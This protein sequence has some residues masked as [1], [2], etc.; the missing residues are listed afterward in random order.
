MLSYFFLL[1]CEGAKADMICAG[2]GRP[3][4]LGWCWVTQARSCLS[5]WCRSP[6]QRAGKRLKEEEASQD[7]QRTACQAC[8]ELRASAPTLAWSHV[9]PHMQKLCLT[10]HLLLQP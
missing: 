9:Q 8:Q 3:G 4:L 6:G 10:S 5:A 7:T 1:L 2:M